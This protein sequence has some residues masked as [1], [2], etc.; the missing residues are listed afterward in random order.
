MLG[1]TAVV[2]KDFDIGVSDRIENG[3]ETFY[4]VRT[5]TPASVTA[6]LNTQ[7]DPEFDGVTKLQ[8]VANIMETVAMYDGTSGDRVYDGAEVNTFGPDGTFFPAG[9]YRGLDFPNPWCNLYLDFDP[10]ANV[11]QPRTPGAVNSPCSLPQ[12][13]RSYCSGGTTTNQCVAILRASAN[14]SVSMATPCTLAI[15]G[16]E[17]A[18][19]GLIFYSITGPNAAPWGPGSSSFLCVKSPTQ[20][21]P[22]QLS[23]GMA[24]DCD[25]E[26]IL[27]WNLYQATH[28]T[29]I[30]QPWFVGATLWGQGWFRDPPAPKTT[31]L[32]NG[33]EMTYVP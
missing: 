3:T 28:P 9:I 22:A 18:K 11:N 4:L 21:T 13:P 15:T 25:G 29:A 14:P 12:P 32:S 19:N 1:D 10:T 30:G 6:L 17:G 24:N 8:C 26:L 16:V 7:L 33:L 27:N 31:N 2:P 20:R 5:P 23:G